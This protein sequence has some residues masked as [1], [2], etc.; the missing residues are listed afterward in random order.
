MTDETTELLAA[1]FHRV[2]FFFM[3]GER[4]PRIPASVG[5]LA[6]EASSF[7][8]FHT[9]FERIGFIVDLDRD[10]PF[11]PVTVEQLDGARLRW[12]NSEWIAM[13]EGCTGEIR[14]A[15]DSARARWRKIS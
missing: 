8:G 1:A 9:Y 15:M 3:V 6:I 7:P 2:A 12:E 11:G 13:P 14:R 10:D 4:F 5:D